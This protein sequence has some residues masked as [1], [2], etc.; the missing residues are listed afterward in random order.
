MK[1]IFVMSWTISTPATKGFNLT[2]SEIANLYIDT[3][4]LNPEKNHEI[5]QFSR[6][7]D[8]D[9]EFGNFIPVKCFYVSGCTFK[10]FNFSK[11]RLRIDS[12]PHPQIIEIYENT[13]ENLK[14]NENELF[15]YLNLSD[16]H[17]SD[18]LIFVGNQIEKGISL[19]GFRFSEVYNEIFWSQLNSNKLFA[20]IPNESE[21]YSSIY[22]AKNDAELKSDI[23][24]KRLLITY[25]NLF[26]IYKHNGDLESANGC[27]SEM[28]DVLGRRMKYVYGVEG[29]FQNYFTW[30]L[31][32]LLKLYTDHGTNP[33]LAI[34]ISV[35]VVIAFAIFYFF[36]PS[37]WDVTSKSKLIQNYKDFV[38]KNDKGYA[39]PFLH[40][41]LG[42]G[43]SLV[44][45]ITLSLN[46][47]T[48]LGFGAIPTRGLARY[49]C[50]IQGFI[51]WFLLSMFTV[52]L[53]NQ[54]L[55]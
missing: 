42:F 8:N 16:N 36:F 49:V 29:G 44:N 12:I 9:P 22:L 13:F 40:L 14:M 1:I 30:K 4:Q 28:K 33:A 47:F 41:I 51:G 39:T 7:Y 3:N 37:E 18:K 17:V 6:P 19:N 5:N 52:A 45:A 31:N 10:N 43:L 11:N 34:Q 46:S 21:N 35:Y 24:F 54:V 53:I 15:S 27:Y 20:I 38:Q 50:I 48:T 55:A 2:R 25:Q 23:N 26:E 32:R